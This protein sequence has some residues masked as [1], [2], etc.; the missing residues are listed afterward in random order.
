MTELGQWLLLAPLWMIFTI[1]FAGLCISAW[2]GWLIRRRRMASSRQ[3]REEQSER[4]EHVLTSVTGLL[5]LLVGFTFAL[6]IDRYDDR[7]ANVLREAN[8][9]GTTYLRAQLLEEPHRSHISRLLVEYTDNRIALAQA[10]TEA[11]SGELLKRND[12]LLTDLWRA[13]V[14][15]FPSMRPY[16]SIS[17]LETMNETIDMDTARKAGRRAHV[18]PAVFVLLFLYQYITAG[19]YG[20]VMV[21][22]TGQWTSAFVMSLFAMAVLFIIDI[23]R[24][25]SG[26]I[27]ESQEPML[28]LQASMHA[29][30]PRAYDP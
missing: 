29:H 6:A 17:F 22:K 20:Y 26:T 7:R 12:A 25:V 10:Q 18:P 2:I 23:D 27:R 28:W 9:I 5:A 13:T 1:L 15:A 4:A 21:G 8:A 24:P 11:R 16:L 14:A 3:K 19:V 30:P